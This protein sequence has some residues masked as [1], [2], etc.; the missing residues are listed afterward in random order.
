MHLEWNGDSCQSA[1]HVILDCGWPTFHNERHER[2]DWGR[3]LALV[4]PEHVVV[5]GWIHDGFIGL[6]PS[7]HLR[8]ELL[9]MMRAGEGGH[10]GGRREGRGVVRRLPVAI[11]CYQWPVCLPYQSP[12]EHTFHVCLILVMAPFMRPTTMARNELRLL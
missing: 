2:H 10:R 6:K 4:A 12:C 3:Q 9:A 1:S 11:T 7:L 8:W 5:A